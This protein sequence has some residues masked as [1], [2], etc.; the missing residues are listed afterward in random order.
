MNKLT[1]NLTKFLQLIN[2]NKIESLTLILFIISWISFFFNP[3]TNTIPLIDFT[4]FGAYIFWI[5]MLFTVIYNYIKQEKTKKLEKQYH[6]ELQQR[7]LKQDQ[8]FQEFLKTEDGKQYQ[9]YTHKLETYIGE[10]MKNNV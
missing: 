4:Y 10:G 3:N 2:K 9:L 1:N 7:V 8:L 5:S 6:E